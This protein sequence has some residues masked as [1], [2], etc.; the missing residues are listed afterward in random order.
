[1]KTLTY[2][3]L[4]ACAVAFLSTPVAANSDMKGYLQQCLCWNNQTNSFC[5]GEKWYES[6]ACKTWFWDALYWTIPAIMGLFFFLLFPV[7]FCCARFLCNCCGGRNP[8]Y[9]CCCPDE[10]S[11]HRFPGYTNRSIFIVKILYCCVFGAYIYYAVGGYVTNAKLHNQV[12]DILSDLDHAVDNVAQLNNDTWTDFVTLAGNGYGVTEADAGR[13]KFAMGT[14]DNR[15]N[16]MHNIIDD[17]RNVENNQGWGRA[18][19][20]YRYPSCALFVYLFAFFFMLCNV[21]KLM[22]FL[23]WLS[24]FAAVTVTIVFIPHMILAQGASAL[25]STYNSTMVPIVVGAVETQDGCNQPFV[26][27]TIQ[28]VASRFEA[29]AFNASSRLCMNVNSLCASLTCKINTCDGTVRFINPN[30]SA[31]YNTSAFTLMVNT[32]GRS[33]GKSIAACALN[34]DGFDGTV[35][36]KAKDVMAFVN[37]TVYQAVQAVT[38]KALPQTTDCQ[39]VKTQ[40][41]GDIQHDVCGSFNTHATNLAVVLGACIIISVIALPIMIRGMKRFAKMRNDQP[42]SEVARNVVYH[43]D[44]QL[45]HID[46]ADA[47]YSPVCGVET[48]DTHAA[49]APSNSEF[50]RRF[51][52]ATGDEHP[53]RPHQE[54]MMDE[55]PSCNAD[56]RSQVSMLETNRV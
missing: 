6:H 32:A 51:Y 41:W 12:V 8:T 33:G 28:R 5:G 46:D 21:R 31:M 38:N 52:G 26:F 7:V 25:C 23:V 56:Q 37:S 39:I 15:R 49:R 9:G 43:A 22:V 17:I 27:S 29:E 40:M 2:V 55:N 47:A 11:R 50:F 53:M 20:V 19:S 3:A 54:P 14:F 4:A 18:E 30:A 35:Q 48:D 24:C 34:C 10:S 1:M 45:N 36:Q 42:L 44:A 13:M 16:Q